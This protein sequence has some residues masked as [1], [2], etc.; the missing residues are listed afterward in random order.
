MMLATGAGAIA[1]YQL[2]DSA[3]KPD[4]PA[5]I[6][7]WA[8]KLQEG[9]NETS[10]LSNEEIKTRYVRDAK[11]KAANTDPAY[12]KLVEIKTLLEEANIHAKVGTTAQIDTA[13]STKKKS[14]DA[15]GRP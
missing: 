1:G 11:L 15:L 5:A 3:T 9:Q 6:K 13:T 7:A 12:L 8:T 2:G 4:N 14:R 10:S